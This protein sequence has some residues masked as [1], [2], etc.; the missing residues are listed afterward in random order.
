MW[1]ARTRKAAFGIV[2]VGASSLFHVFGRKNYPIK[3]FKRNLLSANEGRVSE[4]IVANAEREDPTTAL[5]TGH[6]DSYISSS[7]LRLGVS[8]PASFSVVCAEVKPQARSW[9][10]A[11]PLLRR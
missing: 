4:Q 7:A 6:D 5:T 9:Q 10:E 2:P 8:P 11:S 1:R 3:P